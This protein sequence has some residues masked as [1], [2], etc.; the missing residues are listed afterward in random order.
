MNKEFRTNFDYRQYL[1]QNGEQIMQQ[2]QRNAFDQTILCQYGDGKSRQPYKYLFHD[3]Y[4]P[5]QPFGFESSDLK[6][7]YMRQQKQQL[8]PLQ[9]NHLKVQHEK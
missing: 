3:I 6:T 9:L 4:D 2:Q 7:D 8:I 1:I 5:A